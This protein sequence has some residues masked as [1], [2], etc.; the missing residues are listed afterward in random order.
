MISR[1]T[2]ECVLML[3]ITVLSIIFIVD[4]MDLF[5]RNLQEFFGF[6]YKNVRIIIEMYYFNF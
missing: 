6:L 5:I 2:V 1:S 3:F 4:T